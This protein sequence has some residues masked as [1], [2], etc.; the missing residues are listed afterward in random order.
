M[1]AQVVRLQEIGPS[2]GRLTGA[3]AICIVVAK[4][5]KKRTTSPAEP[6]EGP[7]P[8]PDRLWWIC[9]AVILLVAALFRVWDLD[10]KPLHHDEG[11]NGFFLKNLVEQGIFRYDPANYHGPTLPYFALVS[12]RL[13]GMNTWAIRL[14]PL[15][16]GMGVIGLALALRARIGVWGALAAAAILAVSP[17]AVFHSRYFI[18][19]M[20]LVFFT[21]ALALAGWAFAERRSEWWLVPVALFASLMFA[22]KETCIISYGVL[23]IAAVMMVLD[24]RLIRRNAR[25]GER[26]SWRSLAL[27]ALVAAVLAVLVSAAFYSAFFR[28]TEGLRDS[29]QTFAIWARTGAE[30]HV[31]PFHTYLG[32]LWKMESPVLLLALGG[33][34]IAVLRGTPRFALFC[35]LW[36]WGTLAAYSLIDYKTPWLSLNALV[37]LA[38]VAGFA[39]EQIGRM[40]GRQIAV[41]VVAIALAVGSY[42]AW[43]LNF[44][45]YDDESVPYIYA[46]TDRQFMALI[47]Q[48]RRLSDRAGTGPNT[49]VTVLYPEYWPMPWYLRDYKTTEFFGTV[50]PTTSPIVVGSV[51]LRGEI[52]AVLGP[53]Y[54]FVRSYHQRNGLEVT[55]YVRR[56]IIDCAVNAEVEVPGVGAPVLVPLEVIEEGPGTR[57]EGQ[58]GP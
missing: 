35:A 55:L 4:M 48:I 7:A 46:P 21:A 31:H 39:V 10:L 38:F 49:P 19:E 25:S 22:T 26:R 9:A 34:A 50:V 47:D 56:D 1:P 11:V 28:Y 23:L 44:M 18:H 33:T 54:H 37:P 58:A 36:G 14:V 57:G 40:A 16:F 2:G 12:V 52:E 32:W 41:A 45:R 15:L 3:R 51:G 42:Q 30:A 6:G 27:P 13:F 17:G 8:S 29:L 20:L 5:P 53:D 24:R 43:S